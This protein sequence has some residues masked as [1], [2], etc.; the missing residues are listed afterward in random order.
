[1][2]VQKILGQIARDGTV[3]PICRFVL[4]QRGERWVL[5]AR[6]V[7]AVEAAEAPLLALLGGG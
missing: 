4:S 1:V 7:E 3:Q 5:V 6:E 2:S